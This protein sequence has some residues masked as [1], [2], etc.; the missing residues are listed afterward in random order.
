MRTWV[1]ACMGQTEDSESLVLTFKEGRRERERERE[2]QREIKSQRTA[3]PSD[4]T[5]TIM[6]TNMHTN[7]LLA[8]SLTFAR[9]CSA[10][11]HRGGHPRLEVIAHEPGLRTRSLGQDLESPLSL[12]QDSVPSAVKVLLQVVTR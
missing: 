12:L 3:R 10:F 5:C 11:T 4:H 2:R 8:L 1:A 7:K 9:C 6:L